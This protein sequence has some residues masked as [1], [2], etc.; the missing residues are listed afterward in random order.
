MAQIFLSY[1]RSD[2]EPFVHQLYTDL[3]A[4]GFSIWFDRVAMPSRGLT[5][6]QE[7]RDAIDACERLILVVGPGALHSDYVRAEWQY[8]LQT[9]KVVTPLLRLGD[10]TQLVEG[11][12]L[13]HCPDVRVSRPYDAA[14]AE[15]L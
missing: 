12:T 2:D 9:C 8:A 10:Y 7:I 15:I 11:L 4:R 13:S 1:A 14:L 5:F 6:L 3:T